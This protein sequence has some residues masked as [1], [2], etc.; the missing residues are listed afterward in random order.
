M[1]SENKGI[2]VR[3]AAWQILRRF[4]KPGT[5]RLKADNL[6]HEVLQSSGDSWTDQDRGF[7]TTLVYG[8]LRQWVL[9]D[10]LMA[11]QLSCPIKKVEP[12]VR[13]LIR[14][15]LFQL[16]CLDHIPDYAAIDG[17]VA[18]A[19]KTGCSQKTVGFING[20]LRG[21]Q[22]NSASEDTT[23]PEIKI[24]SITQLAAQKSLPGW[25]ASLLVNTYGLEA[26][27]EMADVIN[28]PATLSLRVNQRR[29]SVEDYCKALDT[30]G[31]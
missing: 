27:A 25:V 4:E 9:L 10:G 23:Q 16:K 5:A 6:I 21:Y 29:T 18:L 8:V 13:T 28:Q 12:K 14:L 15:G 2:E 7:L 26:S 22:R 30:A 3:K 19:K 17:V 1:A 20:V 31:V 11:D 24:D